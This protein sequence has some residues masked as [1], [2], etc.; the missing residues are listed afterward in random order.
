MALKFLGNYLP[1]SAVFSYWVSQWFGFLV[2]KPE[3][4]SS[5]PHCASLTGVGL[6]DRYGPFRLYSSKVKVTESSINVIAST[7]YVHA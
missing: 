6:D 4:G 1:L 2:S 7:A 5:I 3:V